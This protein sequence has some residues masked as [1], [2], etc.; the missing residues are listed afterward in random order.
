[1]NNQKKRSMSIQEA[2]RLAAG[3]LGNEMARFPMLFAKPIFFAN[4]PQ[5]RVKMKVNNM[6]Q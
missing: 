4:P 3:P 5:E 6:G 1:M 2:K